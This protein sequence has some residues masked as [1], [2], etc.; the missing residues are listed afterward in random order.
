MHHLFGLA[1]EGEHLILLHAMAQLAPVLDIRGVSFGQRHCLLVRLALGGSLHAAQLG[2][3]VLDAVLE[4]HDPLLEAGDPV[5]L[6]GPTHANCQPEQQDCH[7]QGF[8]QRFSHLKK[9]NDLPA[10]RSH[11]TS[12]AGRGKRRGRMPAGGG[13]FPGDAPG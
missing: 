10:T 8:H 3:D 13:G 4:R 11:G 5:A 9:V 12:A 7:D 2:V 6:V 1:Q